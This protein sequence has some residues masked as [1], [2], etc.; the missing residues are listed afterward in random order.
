MITFE[1]ARA[2]PHAINRDALLGVTL[3]VLFSANAVLVLTYGL[4]GITGSSMFTGAFLVLSEAAVFMM[5]FRR[6]GLLPAD[7]LFCVL[8]ACIAASFAIN[9]VAEFKEPTLLIVSLAAYPACRLVSHETFGRVIP[10]FLMVSGAIVIIGAICTM[11]AIVDQWPVPRGKPIV[12]GFDAAATYFAGTLGLCVLAIV[13]MPLTLRR[14]AIISAVLFLPTAVVAAAMVRF[15]LLALAGSLCLAAIL[16]AG[17]Q[18]IYVSIILVA[19]VAAVLAGLA[20]RIDTSKK[21]MILAT[22]QTSASDTKKHNKDVSRPEITPPSCNL[23]VNGNNS[24]AIR[25]ALFR[26]AFYLIPTAGFFGVGLD[27]F[28]KFTCLPG[29]QIHVS[30]LQATVEFGW[31]G[32]LS[33]LLLIGVAG[34]SILRPATDSAAARFAL[35]S[36]VYVA[37]ISMAHGRISRDLLL[38]A[39]LGLA[40]GTYERWR[41][42]SS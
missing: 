8:L 23:D 24:V 14:A 29:H 3:S 33:L 30:I 36:L 19:T 5:C 13:T 35:C 25:K 4:A 21:M 31:I 18:R 15:T 1:V 17:R 2:E 22:E 38:F 42:R 26:D 34:C 10:I 32:G 12:F 9:G 6:V 41:I 16:S 28:L 7:Y 11:I 37:A 20:S 40:V 39:L 27:G